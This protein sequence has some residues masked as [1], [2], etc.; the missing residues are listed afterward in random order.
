MGGKGRYFNEGEGRGGKEIYFNYLY[1][2]FKRWEMREDILIVNVF[3]SRGEGREDKTKLL[4][5]PYN[6]TRVS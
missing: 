6:I 2:W 3:G 4:F 5:F 1:V